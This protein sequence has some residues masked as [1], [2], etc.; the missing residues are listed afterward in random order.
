VANAETPVPRRLNLEV[1]AD[2]AATYANFAVIT[3]SP[4]EVFLDF[5]QILPNIP[6]ARVQAR[7]V[8][9]P[10][11]AK[12]LLKALEENMARYEAQYGEIVLPQRS[13]TLADQLFSTI[14]PDD[15]SE[16]DSDEGPQNEQP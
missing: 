2:L 13:Q 15:D 9:T 12:M 10:V 6:K 14:R 16:N 3:H 8:V 11:N 4:W 1:P 7:I 5:A